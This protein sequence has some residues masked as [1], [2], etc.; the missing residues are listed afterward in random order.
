MTGREF[1]W[2]FGDRDV[3]IRVEQARNQG[4]LHAGGKTEQFQVIEM[5]RDRG[6]VE[7]NGRR[8][9]FFIHRNGNIDT[10]WFN[11]RTYRLERV[12]KQVAPAVTNPHGGEIRSAMPGRI[13]RVDVSPGDTVV[14]K[15]PIIIMESMKMESALQAPTSGRVDRILCNAGQIVEMNEL[16]LTIT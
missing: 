4:R 9:T 7:V 6:T 14:E 12:A 16:L 11:G 2:R 15:Q 13:I 3:L 1:H 10:V 8:S 5:T